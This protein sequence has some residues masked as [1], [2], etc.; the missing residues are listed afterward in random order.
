MSED[1]SPT[2]VRTF[3]SIL[4][5]NAWW[6]LLLSVAGAVAAGLLS[7]MQTPDYEAVAKVVVRPISSSPALEGIPESSLLSMETEREIALSP[8]IIEIASR[9]LPNSIGERQ[10]LEHSKVE[11]PTETQVLQI[12]FSS[13]VPQYASEG[14]LALAEAYVGH[15]QLEAAKVIGA[16]VQGYHK[17]IKQVQSQLAGRRRLLSKAGAGRKGQI[18]VQIQSLN[19][20]LGALHGE[21]APLLALQTDPAELLISETPEPVRTT[22]SP[23]ASSIMGFFSSRRSLHGVSRCFVIHSAK[24]FANP[25]CC[26]RP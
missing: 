19:T 5:T 25:A 26:D 9:S 10:L 23:L 1:T 7:Y 12:S 17:Q 2:D 16:T 4:R 24:D 13:P 21:I 18:Q 14:A 6:I 20:R 3:L 15:R 8:P 11:A 22:Q